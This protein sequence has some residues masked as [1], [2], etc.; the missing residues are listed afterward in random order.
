MEACIQVSDHSTEWLE[1]C[2]GSDLLETADIETALL[3][4][5]SCVEQAC[6]YRMV[7]FGKDFLASD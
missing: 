7:A 6:Q 5:A 4:F 3:A 1:T 2:Q